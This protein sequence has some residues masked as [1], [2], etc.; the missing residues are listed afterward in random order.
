MPSSP[1]PT[2]GGQRY[3]RSSRLRKRADFLRVQRSGARRKLRHTV[4]CLTVRADPK[5]CP[6]RF[7]LTVSRKVGPAVVRNRVK[8]RLREAIRRQRGPLAGIDVVFIALPSAA[9]ASYAALC[10]DVQRGLDF[11]RR[12]A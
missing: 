12:V 4:V 10:T 7:G 6:A 1:T 3:P 11:A 5:L 8:R 9:Q 2:P